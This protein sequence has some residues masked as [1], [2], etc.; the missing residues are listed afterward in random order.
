[1][2]T[3]LL[4]LAAILLLCAE[5]S[6][7]SKAITSYFSSYSGREHVTEIALSGSLF[8]ML[9]ALGGSEGS[10]GESAD[11]LSSKITGLHLIIDQKSDD[12]AG[13]FREAGRKLAPSYESL[14]QI[15]DTDDLVEM[16]IAE[17]GGIAEELV[18]AAAHGR[19]FMVMSLSGEI[20]LNEL[21]EL[22]GSM[23]NVAQGHSFKGLRVN[24][25][26]FRL[27]PNPC[28]A[29]EICTLAIPNDML[30]ST[31]TIL[32][33]KG[34]VIEEGYVNEIE[35]SLNLSSFAPGSYTVSVKKGEVDLS[36]K[37]VVE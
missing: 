15:R 9:S 7:Q 28:S 25:A 16:W 19:T 30:G 14:M 17:H 4:F 18:L 34:K 27:S 22:S 24:R 2:K 29:K 11:G 13:A 23:A 1:M 31:Y 32:D 33:R 26:D 21:N 5:A 8:R 35:K 3:Y 10:A 37:L 6:A 36:K 20:D 12:A